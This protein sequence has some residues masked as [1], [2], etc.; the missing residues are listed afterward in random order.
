M[1]SKSI[2]MSTTKFIAVL[3]SVIAIAALVIGGTYAYL[4]ST[5]DEIVNTFSF[6]DNIRVTLTETTSDQYKVVPGTTDQKDPKVKVFSSLP[7]YTFIKI[8]G[9]NTDGVL[10]YEVDPGWSPLTGV[11]GVYYR[12]VPATDNSGS[13]PFS[14]LKDD[15]VTYS[16]HITQETM[17]DHV[18]LTF[19]AYAIQKNP[20]TNA[21]DAWRALGGEDPEAPEASITED[22]HNYETADGIQIH[23]SALI[24]GLED[25]NIK[26]T[27]ALKFEFADEEGITETDYANWNADFVVSFDKPIA[28]ADLQN[29]H[30]GEVVLYGNYTG[31]YDGNSVEWGNVPM[32]IIYDYND[33]SKPLPANTEY[34]LLHN[35][36][37]QYAGTPVHQNEGVPLAITCAELKNY[38]VS[39][40]IC[41]ITVKQTDDKFGEINNGNE[42]DGF[43]NAGQDINVNDM[44]SEVDPDTVVTLKLNIYERDPVTGLETG[45]YKTCAMRQFKIGD[46]VAKWNPDGTDTEDETPGSG[47]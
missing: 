45:V 38:G 24:D 6:D 40:F 23:S 14:V 29:K 12:E 39:P 34:R 42:A 9:E 21:S 11:E 25:I 35:L 28:S 47:N 20:F 37:A 1:N 46:Y 15:Q 22:E 8:T 27:I 5:S 43:H 30:V 18:A 3:M 41:G 33:P 16:S 44:M 32:Y 10:S 26:P 13:E 19:V 36:G 4:T 2:K 17:P 7:T 31:N